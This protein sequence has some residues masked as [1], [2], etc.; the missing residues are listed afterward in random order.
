P[1]ANPYDDRPAIYREAVHIIETH[2]LLGVGPE[3]FVVAATKSASDTQT[4]AP[5]HAHNFL[6]TVA[7]EMG[8]PAALLLVGMTLS[9]GRR[10]RRA[11]LLSSRSERA[12]TVG[13]G[14][15]LVVLVGQ[16]LVDFTMRNPTIFMFVWAMLG[17]TLVAVR[18]VDRADGAPAASRSAD[19]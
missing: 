15:A 2:P 8:L 14:A 10:I 9:V 7:A 13:F 17:M 16:G 5:L 4:V 19:S 11:A 6:L 3:N 1:A 12:L 18:A